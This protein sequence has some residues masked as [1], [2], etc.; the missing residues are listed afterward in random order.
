MKS[1]AALGAG[2]LL[3][4]WSALPAHA[5]GEFALKY[6]D[7]NDG[8]PLTRVACF[9]N[10]SYREK[11]ADLAPPGGFSDKIHFFAF[12]MGGREVRAV[13]DLASPP[14][15]CV[16]AAAAGELVPVPLASGGPEVEGGTLFGP[17]TIRLSGGTVRVRFRSPRSPDGRVWLGAAPAGCMAG[18]VTLAGQ[19]C[20]IALVDNNLDG[21][22]TPM[23]RLPNHH[24]GNDDRL[25][26]LALD[27]NGDG[28][29]L[30]YGAEPAE[31]L[32]LLP[33]LPAGDNLYRVD[34][35]PAGTSVRFTRLEA[36]WGTLDVGSPDL[37]LWVQSD[38][39]LQRLQRLSG[40]TGKWRLPAGKYKTLRV[41]LGR[42]TPD[43]VRWSLRGGGLYQMSAGLGQL[44]QFEIRPEEILTI[45]AGPPLTTRA[46]VH[47]PTSDRK[48]QIIFWPVGQ[49]GEGYAIMAHRDG[50]YQPGAPAARILDEAGH[51]LATINFGWD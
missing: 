28:R 45:R 32:P 14:K 41:E 35:D 7:L 6:I 25:D 46:D 29:F 18:E 40:P 38:A 37:V 36:Q 20:R 5:Q 13:L 3:C 2:A 39:G 4:L 42:L 8:D 31:I 9:P 44:T 12:T 19:T 50:K 47:G 27:V 21:Q 43:G 17:V 33:T 22:Y 15:L 10:V 30:P 34:V 11:P 1:L 26:L 48:F 16:E 49:A 24:T 51:I 23:T